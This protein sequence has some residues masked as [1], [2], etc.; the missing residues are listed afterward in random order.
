MLLEICE[1]RIW[2]QQLAFTFCEY[3]MVDAI[4]KMVQ[5]HLNYKAFLESFFFKKKFLLCVKS[6]SGLTFHVKLHYRTNFAVGQVFFVWLF[7]LTAPKFKT[8]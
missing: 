2:K 1:D 4:M 3:V 5:Y 8:E 6:H 7:D